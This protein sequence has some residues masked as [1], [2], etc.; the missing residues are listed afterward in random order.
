MITGFRLR[1]AYAGGQA[2][3]SNRLGAG[4][5]RARA[6]RSANT[7]PLP[8]RRARATDKERMTS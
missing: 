4:Q 6:G 7:L 2:R 1:P 5:A 8:S 3:P